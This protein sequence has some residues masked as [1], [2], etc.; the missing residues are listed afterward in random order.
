MTYHKRPVQTRKCAHCRTKFESNHK[1]RL[2]CC[3]SCNTLAWRARHGMTAASGSPRLVG[4]AGGDLPFSA[5]TVGVVAAGNLAAQAG[6]Y[7]AQQLWQGGTDTE[8]L[9]AD[10][11][12]QFAA[13]RADLNLPPA[14]GPASFMPAAVRAATGPVRQL[15]PKGGPLRS[16]VQVPYH[17]HLLYYCAAGDVLLWESAP[18]AY[19]RL[20]RAGQ[21]AALAATPSAPPTGRGAPVRLAVGGVASGSASE[22]V[23]DL[24]LD[25]EAFTAHGQAD[26]AQQ[27]ALMAAFDQVLREGWPQIE[28]GPDEE[29]SI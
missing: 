7:V 11:R 20:E 23:V 22:P 19:K 5:H 26:H 4:P 28:P 8:L 2:Y 1:S 16:F 10:V 9:R 18:N 24:A 25:M 3:Q 15:G 12:A 21:L 27:V 6:A 13:L 17:G 29:R 14:P